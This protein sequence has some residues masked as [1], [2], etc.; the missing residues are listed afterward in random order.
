MRERAEEIKA[1][2]TELAETAKKLDMT[3][4][5]LKAVRDAGDKNNAEKLRELESLRAQISELNEEIKRLRAQS[6]GQLGD[7]EAAMRQKLE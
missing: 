5:E 4:M 1:L 3:A 7:L 6:E 2:R